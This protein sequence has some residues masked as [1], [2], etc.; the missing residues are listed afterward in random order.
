MFAPAILATVYE[1]AEYYRQKIAVTRALFR[2]SPVVVFD[3]FTRSIDE[4]SKRS[5]CRVIRQQAGKTV[6]I[7]THTMA[8]SEE[9]SDIVQL[10][11]VQ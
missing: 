11:T 2:D 7:V 4:E 5:I 8:D 1:F 9:S 10:T 6:I 3:A